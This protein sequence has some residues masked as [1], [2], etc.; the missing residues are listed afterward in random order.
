RRIVLSVHGELFTTP[1]DE[2]DLRQITDSP[3]RDVEPKYSPDGKSIAFISDRSGRE[4]LYLTASDGAGEPLK[5]TDLDI[6]KSS[7]SWSPDSKAIA[8]T[9]SDNK[10]RRYTLETKQTAEL[11]SSRYGNLGP[12]VWSPDGKWIAFS[13]P[14]SARDVD[15]YLISSTGGEERKVTF[16]SC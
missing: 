15:V 14:D 5:I 11:S 3:W 1:T 8:F 9:G 10:L 12:P 16:D 4:E 6:L 2:G 7:F 13:K